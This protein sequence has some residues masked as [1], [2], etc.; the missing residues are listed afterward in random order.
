MMKTIEALVIVNFKAIFFHLFVPDG[1]EEVERNV[2]FHINNAC[3][4]V[5]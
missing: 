4:I 2:E 3:A 5:D 1:I